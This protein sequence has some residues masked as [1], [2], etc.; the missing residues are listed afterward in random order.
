MCVCVYIY[1][2]VLTCWSLNLKCISNILHLYSP[3]LT[4][5]AFDIF[6]CG[7]FPTFIVCFCLYSEP[8]QNFLVSS[9]SL[10]FFAREV[11]SAFVVMLVWWC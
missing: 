7:L 5:A 10:F 4:I 1:I 9:C 2:I 3:R 6:V 11:P 8:T